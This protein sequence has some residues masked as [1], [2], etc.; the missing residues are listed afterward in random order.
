MSTVLRAERKLTLGNRDTLYKK[1]VNPLT[2][3]T[4]VGVVVFGDKSLL[5]GKK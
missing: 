3:Q 4:G 2:T 1:N 5:V